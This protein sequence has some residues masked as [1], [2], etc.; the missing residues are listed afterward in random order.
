MVGDNNKGKEIREL[1]VVRDAKYSRA[2][3]RIGK[4]NQGLRRK[5]QIRGEA[6]VFRI[7][8]WALYSLASASAFI[9]LRRHTKYR[10]EM[11]HSGCVASPDEQYR[12]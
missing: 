4:R 10:L 5:R 6:K 1:Y 2:K 7:Q 3:A 9:Q 8:K 11:S 12:S